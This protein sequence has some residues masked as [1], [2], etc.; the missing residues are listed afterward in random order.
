MASINS[1]PSQLKK[2]N[3]FLP[4][5][6]FPVYLFKVPKAHWPK[7]DV[8]SFFRAQDTLSPPKPSTD[9]TFVD[10]PFKRG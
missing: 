4:Q 6:K 1:S 7:R 8:A 5:V 9:D 2:F 10:E 3:P